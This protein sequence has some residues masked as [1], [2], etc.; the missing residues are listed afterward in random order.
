MLT[1]NT[2]EWRLEHQVPRELRLV[3]LGIS[4]CDEIFGLDHKIHDPGPVD[5]FYVSPDPIVS[6]KDCYF[7]PILIFRRESAPL[8][9]PLNARLLME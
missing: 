9:L 8:L 5:E 7:C 1:A 2:Q 3:N 6:G 4:Y